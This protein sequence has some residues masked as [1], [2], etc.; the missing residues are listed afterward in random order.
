VPPTDTPAPPTDTPVPPT[1]T[2]IPPTDTPIPP[3]DTPIPPTDT[4]IPPTDTPVPGADMHVGDLDGSSFWAWGSWVWRATVTIEVH[5]QNHNPVA[6][7][8]VSGA[9][10]GGT[11]GSGQ[12]TTAS[13]GRCSITSGYIWRSRTS[14]TFTVSDVTHATLTFAPADNHDPDGDS[15]GTA[16]TINR[17]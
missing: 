16:I 10:S 13:D 12:C 1:D 5:D 3:T 6:D 4:P 7:A 9:W 11:S 2:P 14:A 15:D 8:T 17:P